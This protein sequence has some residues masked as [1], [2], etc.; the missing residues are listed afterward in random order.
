MVAVPS[1]GLMFVPGADETE[2]ERWVALACDAP[3][4]CRD[5]QST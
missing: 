2:L 3:P 5:V 1:H 4:T